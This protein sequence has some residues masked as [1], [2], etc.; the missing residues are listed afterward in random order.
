MPES[1]RNLF[2]TTIVV[3]AVASRLLFHSLEMHNFATVG[4]LALFAGASFGDRRL[5]FALPMIIMLVSDLIIGVHPALPAV[6]AAMALYVAL[7]L[8]AGNTI[9]PARLVPASLAGSI[10]FF[11]ITNLAVWPMYYSLDIAGLTE[12]FTL[13]LPFF[14]NTVM[15]DL[16]FGGVLFG[17]L[18]LA[19]SRWSALRP[20]NATANA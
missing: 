8:W 6:Y 17:A 19:E 7:G 4:A 20:R 16:M 10:A 18:A 5:A 1:N 14:R 13:A 3:L 15:S 12:C 2:L 9:N 11:V